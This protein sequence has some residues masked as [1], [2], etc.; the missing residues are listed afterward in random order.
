M[1]KAICGYSANEWSKWT[2]ICA[3]CVKM[4][5]KF[6]QCYGPCGI[7]R[8]GKYSSVTEWIKKRGTGRRCFECTKNKE[9]L[10]E[11]STVFTVQNGPLRHT[12][13]SKT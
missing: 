4:K 1:K 10:G 6:K 5:E 7:L 12:L 9:E 2:R 8:T 11:Y 13:P 3:Q